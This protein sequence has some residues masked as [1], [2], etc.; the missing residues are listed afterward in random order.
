MNDVKRKYWWW[1]GG[2]ALLIWTAY[3]QY[4]L[5]FGEPPATRSLVGM[6][7]P[8]AAQRPENAN[9]VGWFD[10]LADSESLGIRCGRSQ[11][12]IFGM[13]DAHRV[14]ADFIEAVERRGYTYE[15]INQIGDILTGTV[16]LVQ[17]HGEGGTYYSMSTLMGIAG[18]GA[19][20]LI[21]EP[22]SLRS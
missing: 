7:I 13:D 18:D 16:T 4:L 12:Y 9:L 3:T 22:V 2:A 21:C 17:H 8:G 10:E 6:Q 20:I 14:V 19:S 5:N 11:L 1:I 15:P